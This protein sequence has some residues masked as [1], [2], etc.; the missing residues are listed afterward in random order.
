MKDEYDFHGTERGKFFRAGAVMSFPIYLEPEIQ[1]YLQEKAQHKGVELT[2]MVN[3]L[4]K[5]EIAIIESV[6]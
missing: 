4:L 2:E 6:R 1:A 3:D 5:R